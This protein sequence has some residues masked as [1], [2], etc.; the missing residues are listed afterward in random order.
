MTEITNELMFEVLKEI[1]NNQKDMK[2]Q[3]HSIREEI[4]AVRTHMAGFQADISNLYSAQVEMSKD[5]ERVR[6][7][8]N[9]TDEKQ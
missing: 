9:L 5:L 6:S 3:L 7:R 1:Q 2:A 8:L 4:V